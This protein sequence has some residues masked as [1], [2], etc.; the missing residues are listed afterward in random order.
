MEITITKENFES[1]II[2]NEEFTSIANML[3]DL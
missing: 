1:G 3:S 2:S